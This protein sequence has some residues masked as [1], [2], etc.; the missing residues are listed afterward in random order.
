V[1]RL[2]APHLVSTLSWTLLPSA[3]EP[4]RWIDQSMVSARAEAGAAASSIQAAAAMK[5]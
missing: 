3:L 4:P 2:R 5:G 1:L